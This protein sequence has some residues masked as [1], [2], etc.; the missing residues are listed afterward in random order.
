MTNNSSAVIGAGVV[1][2]TTA[3]YLAKAG[4]RVTVYDSEHYAGMQTSRANGGQIS[5]SNSQV[6]TTWP[7]IQRGMRWL[8]RPDA[9][10][11]IRPKVD[12]DMIA[13]LWQFVKHTRAN[14]SRQRTQ[15]T[16]MLGLESRVLY[17]DIRDKTGIQFDYAPSGIL[18]VY[19]DEKYLAAAELEG[20]TYRQMGCDW[21]MCT[22]DQVRTLEP[23]LK[24]NSRI[25]GGAWTQ[26]DS[27]GDIHKFCMGLA[28]Y[29]QQ[30]G[31]KFRYGTPASLKQLVPDHDH[32]IV[33][34]GTGSRRLGREIGERLP[35]YP[36]KGYS[37]TVPLDAE[38]R[39][40]AP[41]VS[42]LDDERK[43]VT[44]TLG[45]RL[46]IAGTAEFTGYNTDITMSRV[47]PLLEWC[48]SMFPDLKT[49]QFNPWACLRPMTPDM[50]PIVRHSTT[51]PK[52][53]Y[54]TGHGH[55]GW[56]TAPATAQQVVRLID[57]KQ[58]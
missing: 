51:S 16:I 29:L 55:L 26:S 12:L 33:C 58:H 54:N 4:H 19:T 47:R 9:P 21:R 13:W 40:H 42:L 3:Y 27:V 44:S 2:L 53:Y 18:H 48:H 17:A 37:V 49:D 30:Q 6:W 31:V 32:V 11:L 38:S 50:M 35:V 23:A 1:G 20:R 57:S 56:T 5:V 8:L 43:I 14:T 22:A 46:R 45:D 52:V 10:L 39:P 28:R 15:D 34:A 24:N 7:T 25:I 36:V 41:L